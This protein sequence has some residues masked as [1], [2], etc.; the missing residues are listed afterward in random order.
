MLI[1]L[2]RDIIY[3]HSNNSKNYK[4][5]LIT[6]ENIHEYIAEVPDCFDKLCPAHQADFV[7]V[8]VIEEYGG[9]WLD[10]DTLVMNDLHELFDFIE[11]KNGF[12]LYHH[13]Q[14]LNCVF[15][16]KPHTPFMQEWKREIYHILETKG[17]KIEWFD[18]G[19]KLIREIYYK[20]PTLF[21]NYHV[22]EGEQSIFPIQSHKLC[23][24]QYIERPYENCFRLEK[25]FQPLLVLI[26]DVYNRVNHFSREEFLEKPYPLNYFISKALR[27]C[28]SYEESNLNS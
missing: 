5:H 23:Y 6:P 16:S 7:R 27:E 20:Q 24:Q 10:S 11:I 2:L 12:L 13:R 8:C 9:I 28:T 3:Q 22:L 1:K 15:G 17:E 4:V 25:A 18:I 14:I 26:A 21:Y 19:S